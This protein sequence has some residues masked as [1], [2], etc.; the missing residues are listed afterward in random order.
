MSN[1][2]NLFIILKLIILII[3]LYF[4]N[5]AFLNISTLIYI[6]IKEI[7]VLILIKINRFNS[8]LQFFALIL[9]YILTFII[10]NCLFIYFLVVNSKII[11][12]NLFQIEILIR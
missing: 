12:I 10:K 11:F 6:L 2:L 7:H 9:A 4:I 3:I 5:L 8:V 1:L